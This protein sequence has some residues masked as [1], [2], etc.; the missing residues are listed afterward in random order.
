MKEG[1]RKSMHCYREGQACLLGSLLRGGAG[2]PPGLT[3]TGRG[4]PASWAHCYRGGAG[5]PSGLTATGEGQARLLGSL[6]L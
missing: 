6:A 3:A 4:R 5:Q 2:R 1:G